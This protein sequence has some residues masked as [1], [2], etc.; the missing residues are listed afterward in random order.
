MAL[1]MNKQEVIDLLRAEY[2]AL[3]DLDIALAEQRE[4]VKAGDIEAINESTKTVSACSE[5]L[6][7]VQA[8]RMKGAGEA[9]DES[10]NPL[11]RVLEELGISDSEEVLTLAQ[12]I[13]AKQLAVARELAVNRAAIGRA[14]DMTRVTLHQ[15]GGLDRKPSYSPRSRDDKEIGIMFDALA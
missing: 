6:A 3:H 15:I 9:L 10:F 14:L 12:E 1:Q 4:A 11:S 5:R 8:W 7:A 13:Q 2:A